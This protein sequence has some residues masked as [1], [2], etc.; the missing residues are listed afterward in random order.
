MRLEAAQQALN[1]YHRLIEEAIL[2][3]RV[4]G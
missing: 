3:T 2:I 1:E 4:Y